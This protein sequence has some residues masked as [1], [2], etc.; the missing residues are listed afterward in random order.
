VG[1]QR[2]RAGSSPSPQEISTQ[3]RPGWGGRETHSNVTHLVRKPLAGTGF[4]MPKQRAFLVLSRVP[5]K[6]TGPA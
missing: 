5:R 1:R 6:P 3:G 4:Y 2:P